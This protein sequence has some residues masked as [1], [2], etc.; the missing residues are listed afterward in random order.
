MPWS[1]LQVSIDALVR[2]AALA[3]ANSALRAME[4][5]GLGV[6]EHS[7][8]SRTVMLIANLAMMTGNIGRPGVGVNPLRGQNNVQ[9]AADMGVQ[10]H[11]G[12]GYMDV[13]DP[14][15]QQLYTE[16]YGRPVPA[17][18]GYK[19]PQMFNAAI[20]GDLKALWIMGEDVAQTDPN[21]EHVCHALGGRS[22]CWSCKTSFS[23]KRPSWRML[24]C[25]PHR[26]WKRVAR[27]PMASDVSNG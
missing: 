23:P 16:H 19:I 12:A 11:Q 22:N 14:E 7:Q 1:K 2:E 8:G 18:V 10:P 27:L 3:Y 17:H 6:T 24:C 9:G 5:H 4:F 15:V 21:A 25:R 26:S 13:T 20:R